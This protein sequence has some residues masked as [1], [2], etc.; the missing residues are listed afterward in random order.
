VKLNKESLQLLIFTNVSFAN[1]KDLSSQISY[2]LV[3]I[4]ATRRANILH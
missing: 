1:N 2:I 3:L 4:D